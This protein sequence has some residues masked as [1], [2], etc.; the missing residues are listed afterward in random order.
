MASREHNIQF[1]KETIYF[2]GGKLCIDP[3]HFLKKWKEIRAFVFDWDGVFNNAEKKPGVPSGFS[4]HDSMGLNML[5][6]SYWLKTGKIIPFVIIT[7]EG[8]PACEYFALREKFNQVYTRCKRKDLGINDFLKKGKL[9]P[10][11]IACV[12][13]DVIDAP[14]ARIS[15]LRFLVYASGTSYWRQYAI[16]N[17]LA[18]YETLHSGNK[19]A[20]R[21]ISEMLICLNNNM[22]EVFKLREIFEGKYEEYLG[23]RDSVTTSF[24]RF[25]GK[26]LVNYTPPFPEFY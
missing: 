26:G 1:L 3:D 18:D 12:F 13:D 25:E 5:R 7:G 2:S 4:E 11:Q 10:E 15:G 14:M 9:K 23:K 24:N 21:E 6:F 16:N 22:E 19:N 8:N 17:E 20:I